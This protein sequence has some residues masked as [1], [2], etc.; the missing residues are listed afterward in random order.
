MAILMLFDHDKT[1]ADPNVDYLSAPKRGHIIE[2]Y[3]D[4][5]PF[6]NPPSPP[7]LI[8]KVSNVTKAQVAHYV[9]PWVRR[10]DYTVVARSVPQDGWRL[11]LKTTN[12]NVSGR[13]HITL[14]QAQ[15]CLNGWNASVIGIVNDALRFDISIFGI[16]TSPTYWNR[17][18]SSVQF[19]EVSYDQATGIHRI[20]A[21]FDNVVFP[22][23]VTKDRI[24][25]MITRAV[26]IRGGSIVSVVE[27]TATYDVARDAVIGDFRSAVK[28]KL[29][30]FIAQKRYRFDSTLVDQILSN[31]RYL[32]V[33]SAVAQSN[34]LDRL[35]E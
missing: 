35:T 16:A 30:D 21:N 20:S 5:K 2:V 17:D 3:E 23:G 25:A 11:D 34:L 29:E 22:P 33:S 9:E 14:G 4:S 26:A 8:L 13:G 6:V 10:V 18:V 12:P 24:V 27:K 19:S 7:W 28:L 31:G 32:E 1:F 15:D